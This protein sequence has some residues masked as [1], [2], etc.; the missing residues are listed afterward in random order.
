MLFFTLDV[1][2]VVTLKEFVF[3][4][5]T[6]PWIVAYKANVETTTL[7]SQAQIKTFSALI[8]RYEHELNS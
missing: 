6:H 5:R 2:P 7:W 1:L 8:S 4:P 3:L